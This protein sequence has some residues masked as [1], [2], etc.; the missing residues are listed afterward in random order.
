M[1]QILAIIC[2]FILHITKATYFI[3]S[4]K[5]FSVAVRIFRTLVWRWSF[6]VCQFDAEILCSFSHFYLGYIGKHRRHVGLVLWVGMPSHYLPF[7]GTGASGQPLHENIHGRAIGARNLCQRHS[8]LLTDGS[9]RKDGSANHHV[10]LAVVRV[11]KVF[12]PFRAAK[13]LARF[14]IRLVLVGFTV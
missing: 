14:R 12:F 2:E 11:I 5:I 8:L 6:S 3:R 7:Q 10:L 9:D 13:L 1:T 4:W